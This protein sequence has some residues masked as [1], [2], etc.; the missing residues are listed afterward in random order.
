MTALF[1]G[2]DAGAETV[3]IKGTGSHI[4]EGPGFNI[5]IA[6]S[7]ELYTPDRGVLHGITRQMIFDLAASTDLSVHACDM[8]EAQLR[9]ADEIFITST[10]GEI[11]PVTTLNGVSIGDGK[12]GRFTRELFNAYWHDPAWTLSVAYGSSAQT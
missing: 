1:E 9:D 11:I 8:S 4:A 12:P 5:F 6:K 7:G 3:V 10:A 2:Y